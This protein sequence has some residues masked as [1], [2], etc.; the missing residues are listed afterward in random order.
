MP[1]GHTA[2]KVGN[3][4]GTA[5]KNQHVDRPDDVDEIAD[6]RPPA[7]QVDAALLEAAVAG[8]VQAMDLWLERNGPPPYPTITPRPV[9]R[10]ALVQLA[11]RRMKPLG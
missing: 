10:P 6:T 8:N 4:A 9:R 2:G 7:E 5:T 3:V 1:A 11:R